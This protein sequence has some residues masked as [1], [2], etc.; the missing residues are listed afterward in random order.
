M[1]LLAV[2]G[3][4]VTQRIGDV[5]Q[6]HEAER[7]LEPMVAAADAFPVPAGATV[8]MEPYKS[9]D[10]LEVV[11]TWKSDKGLDASCQLWKDAF[12]SW[13]GSGTT[14]DV[15]G[16][17]VPGSSCAFAARR[18]PYLVQLQLASYSGSAPQATLSVLQ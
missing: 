7:A 1:V 10:P 2:I 6:Q 14:G 4:I 3:T 8:A 11:R 17:A 12:R 16:E 18:G 5:R 15:T 13:A 9:T